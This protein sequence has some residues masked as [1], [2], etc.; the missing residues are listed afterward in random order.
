MVPEATATPA[1]IN[2]VG[3]V[4]S[5]AG[6]VIGL[7]AACSENAQSSAARLLG[8]VRDAIEHADGTSGERKHME[9]LLDVSIGDGRIAETLNFPEC[10]EVERGIADLEQTLFGDDAGTG[11]G[12]AAGCQMISSV[13]RL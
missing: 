7:A 3:K 11:V 8:E 13:R 6:S 12:V 5:E 4:V 1:D 2:V 9:V 10:R